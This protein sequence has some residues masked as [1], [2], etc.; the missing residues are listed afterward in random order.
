MEKNQMWLNKKKRKAFYAAVA[1][2][3]FRQGT[4]N[5]MQVHLHVY[6]LDI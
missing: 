3:S 6:Y 1:C 2:D 5:L 4:E